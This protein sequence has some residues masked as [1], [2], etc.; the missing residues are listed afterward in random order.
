MRRAFVLRELRHTLADVVV[1]DKDVRC[2]QHLFVTRT[3]RRLQSTLV[4]AEVTQLGVG[5][6][7][8][9]TTYGSDMAPPPH[10]SETWAG[11]ARVAPGTPDVVKGGCGLRVRQ[12]SQY[13]HAFRMACGVV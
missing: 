2:V 3:A 12:S 10:G 4:V 6:F 5:A 9:N 1:A 7:L 11:G 8:R 13:G